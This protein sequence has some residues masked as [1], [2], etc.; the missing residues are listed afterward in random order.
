[1]QGHL[2]LDLS[3]VTR[4]RGSPAQMA[5]VCGLSPGL[6]TQGWLTCTL[7]SQAVAKWLLFGAVQRQGLVVGSLY[8]Y[9]CVRPLGVWDRGGVWKKKSHNLSPTNIR[10]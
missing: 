7:W 4:T 9:M 8:I 10:D 6:S 1:M 3:Q 5:P 2:L